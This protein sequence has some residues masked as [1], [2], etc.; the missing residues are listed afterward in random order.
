[1]ATTEDLIRTTKTATTLS[2]AKSVW[3]KPA[4]LSPTAVGIVI[5]QSLVELLHIDDER[6]WVEEIPTNEG[7]LLRIVNGMP[8]SHPNEKGSEN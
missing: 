6:T 3:K 8:S 5:P 1:M 4:R 7:L 2:S